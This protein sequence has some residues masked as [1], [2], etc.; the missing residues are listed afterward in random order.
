ML[1]GGRSSFAS[2]SEPREPRVGVPSE[3]LLPPHLGRGVRQY[4]ASAPNAADG[5]AARVIET[6]YSLGSVDENSNFT[7]SE[8]PIV[9]APQVGLFA[10]RASPT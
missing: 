4:H 3:L 1:A 7:L 9:P 2:T 6:E 5:T 8:D 10:L